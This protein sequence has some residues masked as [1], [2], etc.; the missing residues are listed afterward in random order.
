VTDPS[1]DPAATIDRGPAVIRAWAPWCHNCRVLAP[2]VEEEAGARTG[3]RS[4]PVIDARVDLEPDLVARFAIRS[5]PTLIA[6]RDGTEIGRLVG[7]QSSAAVGGLFDA[8]AGL[9]GDVAGA[10]PGAGA[11]RVRGVP[12]APLVIGRVAAGLALTLAGAVL[13]S[14]PLAVIGAILSGWGLWSARNVIR[15]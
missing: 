1:V 3:Q 5:V 6:V 14:I 2:V 10:G 7:L 4:V 13:T 9:A 15:R 11:M 8:A 12:P